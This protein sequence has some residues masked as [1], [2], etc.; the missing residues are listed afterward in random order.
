MK[1]IGTGRETVSRVDYDGEQLRKCFRR[2]YK[3][4]MLRT[5]IDLLSVRCCGTQWEPR[6]ADRPDQ[7]PSDRAHTP[8]IA[9]KA[10]TSK[11]VVVARAQDPRE[12]EPPKLEEKQSVLEKM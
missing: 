5:Y 4:C 9:C 7:K 3:V 12:H 2:Q 8:I 10:D 1:R 11:D 6:L